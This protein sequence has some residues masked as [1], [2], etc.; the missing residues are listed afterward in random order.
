MAFHMHDLC[1]FLR[2]RFVRQFWRHLSILS[3]LT[4]PE[5]AIA[6][7][8]GCALYTVCTSINPQRMRSCINPAAHSTVLTGTVYPARP[9][10]HPTT[11]TYSLRLS[12][13]V[14]KKPLSSHAK[15]PVF[16]WHPLTLWLVCMHGITVLEPG[17]WVAILNIG[18]ATLLSVLQ[19]S[20]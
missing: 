16:L 4:L 13:R 7:L 20:S 10:F 8:N 17:K 14:E 15:L 1:G 6:W 5:L 9:L 19:S 2:K 11:F 18:H 12:L 3:F